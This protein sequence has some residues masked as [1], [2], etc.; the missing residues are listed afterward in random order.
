MYKQVKN[1]IGNI[2]GVQKLTN[3]DD[4]IFIPLPAQG[5]AGEEYLAWI[6][7]GNTPLPAEENV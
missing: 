1:P 7:E 6:A 2:S 3:N 5:Q 4:Y